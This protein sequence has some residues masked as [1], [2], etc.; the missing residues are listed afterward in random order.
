MSLT[1]VERRETE[2]TPDVEEEAK[3]LK[4]QRVRSIAIALGLVF[5]VFLFYAASIVKMGSH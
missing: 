3:R 5:L 4:R 1:D 2:E